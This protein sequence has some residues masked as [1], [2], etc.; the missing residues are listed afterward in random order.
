MKKIS[1]FIGVVIFLYLIGTIVIRNLMDGE[2]L[3][4]FIILGVFVIIYF[5][6]KSDEKVIE[7][8]NRKIKAQIEAAEKE[9][10][11]IQKIE[12]MSEN[13]FIIFIKSNY[14]ELNKKLKNGKIIKLGHG[15][16]TT[17]YTTNKYLIDYT[18]EDNDFNEFIK[19]IRRSDG[20]EIFSGSWGYDHEY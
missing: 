16:S 8:N 10:S 6:V 19:I 14:N 4:F 9:K 2:P 3:P 1:E 20:V 5:I 12:N 13:E 17:R 7:E 18:I 11:R 15:I